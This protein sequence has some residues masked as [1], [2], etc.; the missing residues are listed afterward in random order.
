M[1]RDSNREVIIGCGPV[2]VD[3]V[4][5]SPPAFE[6]PRIYNLGSATIAGLQRTAAKRFKE[7]GRQHRCGAVITLGCTNSEVCSVRASAQAEISPLER[8]I[9]IRVQIGLVSAPDVFAEVS[10]ARSGGT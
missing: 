3:V 8:F 7:R 1:E 9:L 6:R 10:S 4:T 5:G 2:R